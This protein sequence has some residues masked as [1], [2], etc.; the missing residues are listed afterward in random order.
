MKMIH[1]TLISEI[2]PSAL[3]K[4]IPHKWNDMKLLNTESRLAQV[5]NVSVKI[6][7]IID[8]SGNAVNLIGSIIEKDDNQ[9]TIRRDN[10]MCHVYCIN[11]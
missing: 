9:N 10:V 6:D 5:K 2:T 11:I 3:A 7:E 4:I 8:G 1:E